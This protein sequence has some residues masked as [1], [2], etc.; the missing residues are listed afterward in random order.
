M[1]D[2]RDE[3]GPKPLSA[4]GAY[5]H[6]LDAITSGRIKP[7]ERV[8]EERLAA[9]FGISRTPVREAL[10]R[11]ETQG[12]LVHAPHKGM[13]VRQLDHQSVTELYFMREV[14]ESAAA[15]LAARHATDV[16]IEVMDEILAA[17]AHRLTDAEA[18]ALSNKSFHETLYQVAHNRYLVESLAGLR[19]A[20]SLLGPTTLGIP[21]RPEEA[22]SEHRALLDAIKARDPAAAA[23]AAK[24]HIRSAHKAR[25]RRMG[26][27]H[28]AER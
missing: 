5:R 1:A 27:G 22:A 4:D 3:K 24:R 16:E 7:G 19:S 25:L 28:A 23:G 26:T 10:R 9:E 18:M 13:I 6:V 14:L 8:R 20:M 21:G 17:D 12:L 2:G 11:L 15:E